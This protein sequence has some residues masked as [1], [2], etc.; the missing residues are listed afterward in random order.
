MLPNRK[1]FYYLWTVFNIITRKTLLEYVRN[2]LSQVL[3]F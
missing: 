3:H 1:H 2:T